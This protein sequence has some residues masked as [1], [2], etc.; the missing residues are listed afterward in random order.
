MLFVDFIRWWYGP[1]W[2]LRVRMLR[3]HLANSVAFFSLGTLL[4]TLFAPWRQNIT[5]TR[6]DESIDAKFRAFLDNLISR[7]VGFWVRI[8]VLITGISLLLAIAIVNMLYVLIWPIIP[9][10]PAILMSLGALV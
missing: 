5:S 1:G 8:F 9:L 7:F 2:A 10:S 4:K 3:E 6:P